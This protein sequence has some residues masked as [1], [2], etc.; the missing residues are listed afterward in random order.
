MTKDELFDSFIIEFIFYFL[1]IIWVT[2]IF[3]NFTKLWN[4]DFPNGKIKKLIF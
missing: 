1:R 2:K 3:N 4:I